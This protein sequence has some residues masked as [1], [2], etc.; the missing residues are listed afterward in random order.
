MHSKILLSTL[1]QLPAILVARLDTLEVLAA[2]D[3]VE[4]TLTTVE[5]VDLTMDKLVTLFE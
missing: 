5:A 2:L 3:T 1:F 4:E